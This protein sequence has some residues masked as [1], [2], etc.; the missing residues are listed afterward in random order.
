MA[1][2]VCILGITVKKFYHGNNNLGKS[3]LDNQK[4]K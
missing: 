2:T 4:S 3:R 1:E